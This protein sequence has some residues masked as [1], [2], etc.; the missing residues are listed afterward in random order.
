MNKNRMRGCSGRTSRLETT[1]SISIKGHGSKFGG[2]AMKAVSLTSGGLRR[3]PESGLGV[4]RDIPTAAQKSAAG[5]VPGGARV[6]AGKAQT[7]P[8]VVPGVNGRRSRTG[9]S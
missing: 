3:V 6:P 7:V 5:I 9:F 4:S 8:P 2:C 1:K